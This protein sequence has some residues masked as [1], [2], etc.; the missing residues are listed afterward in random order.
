MQN[1][2]GVGG[3]EQGSGAKKSSRKPEHLVGHGSRTIVP[4][5]AGILSVGMQPKFLG[6]PAAWRAWLDK[7]HGPRRDHLWGVVKKRSGE[8]RVTTPLCSGSA[9]RYGL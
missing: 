8:T 7:Y 5:R 2:V 3:R 6:T 4:R 9:D 1:Q